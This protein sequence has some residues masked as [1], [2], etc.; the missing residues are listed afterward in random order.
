MEYQIS[1]QVFGPPTMWLK[2]F[3][4]PRKRPPPTGSSFACYAEPFS[5]TSVLSQDS[6]SKSNGLLKRSEDQK[7][8]SFLASLRRAEG[9]TEGLQPPFCLPSFYQ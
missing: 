3:E 2:V 6:L 9:S 5:P 1:F 4:P 7:D 8:F